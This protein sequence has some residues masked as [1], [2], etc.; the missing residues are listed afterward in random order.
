MNDGTWNHGYADANGIRIHYVRHGSGQPLVLLHGWPE[1]WY[2]W[3]KNIPV[4][5]ESFDVIAPDLRGFGESAKPVGSA[6]E[7]YTLDHHVAD[8]E[9]LANVLGIERF[10]IVSHD[11]GAMVAQ[12]F[13]R[14]SPGRL[15]G[16]FFFNCPYPGIGARWAEPGHLMEIWYQ[17]FNQQPWAA[18]LIGHNR[19]TCRLYIGNLLAHWAHR[20]EAFDDDLE[21]WVD[22]FMTPGNLDGGFN[23]YRAIHAARLAIIRGEMPPPP[24][25]EVPNSVRWGAH[26]SV[27]RL[28][29]ADRLSE[30]F[31]DLDFKP[32]PEA[33]HFVHYEQP[34]YANRE[35]A[36]FFEGLA[37]R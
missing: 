21:A 27:L 6:T 13:A 1:F 20:P 34:K 4:L 11:V 18:A 8:L 10:G 2:V 26:D 24:P 22:N 9:A 5:A 33:G 17:A 32:A 30:Y 28:D 7:A 14:K 3:R 37:M 12:S 35:I 23:W 25:I 19:E 29:F 31:T 15:T 36:A 16:L